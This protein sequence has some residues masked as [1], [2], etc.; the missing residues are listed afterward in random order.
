MYAIIYKVIIHVAS[1]PVLLDNCCLYSLSLSVMAHPSSAKV[2]RNLKII[3]C[4]SFLFT[5][6]Y[7]QS[8][9]NGPV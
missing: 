4:P 8:S 6:T 9:G 2:I 5:Q 3:K 7:C 1:I